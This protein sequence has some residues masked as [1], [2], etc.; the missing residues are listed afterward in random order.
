MTNEYCSA[1]RGCYIHMG[2]LNLELVYRGKETMEGDQS[3]VIPKYAFGDI[4][5]KLVI[6]KKQESERTFHLPLYLP[7]GNQIEK[8]S[9]VMGAFLY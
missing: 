8:P 5:F 1:Q 2:L 9:I 6:I 7:K 3:F 4:N